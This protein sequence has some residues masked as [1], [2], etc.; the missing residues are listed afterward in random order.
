MLLALKLA[1][2]PGFL[3]ALTMAGRVWGPSVAGWL[4]GLPVVAGP[5]V[6]L[7]ALERGPAFAAQASAASI[8]A[9]AASE[10]FNVAYAWT[11]RRSAWPLALAAGMLGWGGVALLLTHLPVGLWWAVGA[12]C[13]A[14]AVS[15]SGLPRVAGHVPAAR[16][17]LGDLA[18]RMLAGALLTVAVTTLSASMGATWSGL[19][20]VFP[21][22]GIVLAVSAQR[23]HGADFV[24][25]LMRGM[26][27]GRGSFAAFF[28]VT[29]TM[30]PHYGVWLSFACAAVVSMAVQGATR[31]LLRAKRPVRVLTRQPTAP[32]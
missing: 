15:Q 19:L 11:C 18:L 14:V 22:L 3:A 1:L 12:A 13:V 4:A 10:A 28:A 25:L 9:I 16:V 30:L 2:V 31:R 20:S 23:A 6:L 8:A 24:A 21:L 32:L 17:G 26:V 5:I 7:L 29:A 27:I